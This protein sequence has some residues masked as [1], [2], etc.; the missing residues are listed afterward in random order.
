MAV[1]SFNIYLSE[2]EHARATTK[3]KKHGLTWAEVLMR[4]I[5]TLD[6]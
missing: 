5:D 6:E 4:G 3:K 2:E 1:K